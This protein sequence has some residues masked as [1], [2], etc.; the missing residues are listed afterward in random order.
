MRLH[1]ARRSTWGCLIVFG[2]AMS[3][4]TIFTQNR[5]VLQATTSAARIQ[6]WLA[7]A[8]RPG[9]DPQ[10]GRHGPRKADQTASVALQFGPA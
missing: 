5:S 7:K 2:L 1:A 4:F 8:Q 10:A 3:G 6:R 9:F